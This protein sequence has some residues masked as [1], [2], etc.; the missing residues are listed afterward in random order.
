MFYWHI[1]SPG[2]SETNINKLKY[3]QNPRGEME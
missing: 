1:L 2:I 3:V